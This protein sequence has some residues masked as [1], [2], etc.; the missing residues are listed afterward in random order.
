VTIKI[1]LQHIAQ[2]WCNP[3]S[4]PTHLHYDSTSFTECNGYPMMC[5]D[6]P[7]YAVCLVST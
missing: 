2:Q 6:L 5:L 4:E 3:K 7:H 1:E